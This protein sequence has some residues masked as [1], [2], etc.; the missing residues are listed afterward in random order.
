MNHFETITS[1]HTKLMM[2]SVEELSVAFLTSVK[3]KKRSAVL[4]I[5]ETLAYGKS[6]LLFEL[7]GMLYY[8]TS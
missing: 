5:V 1:A 6:F 3:R 2:V 8:S 7:E 4:P